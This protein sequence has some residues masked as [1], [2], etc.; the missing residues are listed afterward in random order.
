M[1]A[2]SRIWL[3]YEEIDD[4]PEPGCS[5]CPRFRD[6]ILAILCD[7][8]DPLSTPQILVQLGNGGANCN[9]PTHLECRSPGGCPAWCWSTPGPQGPPV[10]PQL[11]ALERVGLVA[12]VH[13]PNPGSIAKAIAAGDLCG[14][15]VSADSRCVY[16]Q[17]VDVD[18]DEA[19]NV[20][21]RCDGNALTAWVGISVHRFVVVDGVDSPRAVRAVIFHQNIGRHTGRRR[22]GVGDVR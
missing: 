20:R 21:A 3:S 5:Y 10:Y 22:S 17:Y 6:Q 9:K 8:D 2:A 14:H 19:L 16:W 18:T 7:A 4:E 15:L 12:R 13:Y 11:R 1:G